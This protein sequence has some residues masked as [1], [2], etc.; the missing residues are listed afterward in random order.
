MVAAGDAIFIPSGP[1]GNHLFIILNDP[2]PLPG[3]GVADQCVLVNLSTIDPLMPYDSTHVLQP[4]AHPF[5]TNPSYVYY[6]GARVDRASHL[7][8]CINKGTFIIRPPPFTPQQV[9]AIKQGLFT[10]PKVNRE[11]KRLPI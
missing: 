5:I 6:R 7:V 11:L 8:D 1:Q 3:Y 4:G 2:K 9:A 10:S